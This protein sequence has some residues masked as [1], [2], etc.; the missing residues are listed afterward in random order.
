M[1]KQD[2]QAGQRDGATGRINS[3]RIGSKDYRDGLSRG[4]SAEVNRTLTGW[5][6][7][8]NPNKKK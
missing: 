2:R 8:R 7:K 5:A 6:G 4:R 1:A 3:D